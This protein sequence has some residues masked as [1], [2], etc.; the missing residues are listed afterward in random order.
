MPSDTALALPCEQPLGAAH[1]LPITTE[2]GR[3]SELNLPS[4]ITT[5]ALA[6]LG[7]AVFAVDG[8]CALK[9]T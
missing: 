6:H 8:I 4:A 9:V 5:A 2:D 3:K 1:T 7:L